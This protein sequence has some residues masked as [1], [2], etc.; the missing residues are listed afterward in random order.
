MGPQWG[1]PWVCNTRWKNRATALVTSAWSKT[2]FLE[3][4]Y[5]K[6]RQFWKWLRLISAWEVGWCC[7]QDDGRCHSDQES[8][9]RRN[10]EENIS[11]DFGNAQLA[12]D[13]CA[14]VLP[15]R[16][17]LVSTVHA[18]RDRHRHS[19]GWR[20][21]L[22]LEMTYS[23][24]ACAGHPQGVPR[25]LSWQGGCLFSLLFWKCWGNCEE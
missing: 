6:K 12:S 7:S 3:M 11:S 1:R 20:S 16:W 17:G 13:V 15:G 10:F 5:R 25:H 22:C 9:E 19:G 24:F 21:A 4:L 8:G 18:M 14:R 23:V 2:Q